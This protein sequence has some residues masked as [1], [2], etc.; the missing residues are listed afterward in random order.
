MLPMSRPAR[1]PR[2]APISARRGRARRGL[3]V[4]G[5]ALALAGALLSVSPPPEAWAAPIGIRA[6]TRVSVSYRV[7]AKGLVVSGRLVDDVDAPVA[8][9][10]VAFELASMPV[11]IARTDEDGRFEAR[12]ARQDLVAAQ[13]AFGPLLPWTFTF[14]GNSQLGAVREQGALDFSKRPTRLV[15]ALPS[16]PIALG[17]RAVEAVVTLVEVDG[18]RTVAVPDAEIA[19]E[20]GT[21]SEL[22]GATGRA[23]TATFVVRPGSLA[24][25]GRYGVVAR[26]KGDLER[27]PS[28][29][30][31]TIEVVLPSRITLR[32]VREGDE[33]SGRYRF[34]GRLSDELGPIGD[35]VVN[36]VGTVDSAKADAPGFERAV[37]TRPD[38]LFVTAISAE[39][40]ASIRVQAEARA[41]PELGG[42]VRLE[43]SASFVPADGVHAGTSS[44]PVALEIPPPPGIPLRWYAVALGL[45]LALVLTS[46]GLRSGRL[47][48]ASRAAWARV[49]G[50]CR[51]TLRWL[52]GLGRRR[53]DGAVASSPASAPGLVALA[54][55]RDARRVDHLSGVIVDQDTRA[56]IAA[57]LRARRGPDAAPQ[58]EL[59]ASEEGRFELGPLAPGA[60]IVEVASPGYLPREVVLEVPHA[61]ELD[62]VVLG[63]VEIRRTVREVFQETVQALGA[64]NVWGY[65]TPRETAQSVMEA[66]AARAATPI[67]LEGTPLVELVTLVERAHFARLHATPAD[68]DRARALQVEL[69]PHRPETA[70]RRP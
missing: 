13:S 58:R 39:E 55:G 29:A 18:P 30:E 21:G 32:V 31:G 38:G 11:V 56:P 57:R 49:V 3:R 42:A 26:F 10:E 6:R 28:R 51:A 44:H 37:A 52:A 60:W 50:A 61:G 5:A 15:I 27:A 54:S 9:E 66:H 53:R 65:D 12:F 41:G 14:D 34:S 43:V 36:V 8:K 16:G 24:S 35:A 22:V 4:L 19:V 68:V 67:T 20:V 47:Q 40:M 63:L 62:G 23:G 17:E 46:R 25:A 33:L 2:P 1:T 64:A 45:V 69:R 48:R 70:E 59:Q 7:D